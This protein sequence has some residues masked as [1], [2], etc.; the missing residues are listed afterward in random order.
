MHACETGRGPM[1]PTR[2]AGHLHAALNS[3]GE[4]SHSLP[5]YHSTIVCQRTGVLCSSLSMGFP[6]VIKQTVVA[7]LFILEVREGLPEAISVSISYHLSREL[8][9]FSTML[10]DWLLNFIL[11]FFKSLVGSETFG[12]VSIWGPQCELSFWVYT[13]FFLS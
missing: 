7:P 2:D 4:A 3:E 5:R 9:Y 10:P 11:F 6:H 13:S 1:P 8:L 12:L